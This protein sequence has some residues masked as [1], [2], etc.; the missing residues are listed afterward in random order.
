M[1]LI[2]WLIPNRKVVFHSPLRADELLSEINRITINS[3]PFYFGEFSKDKS[4]YYYGILSDNHFKL[5]RIQYGNSYFGGGGY[6][7][8][9]PV[10]SGTV[11]TAEAGSEIRV[12]LRLNGFV[13][14]LTLFWFLMF[15][16]ITYSAS[17]GNMRLWLLAVPLYFFFY[18]FFLW[19][20]VVTIEDLSKQFQAQPRE[21][22][23]P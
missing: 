18:L 5:R 4:K 7:M 21:K 1:G 11:E 8:F 20:A 6:N 15:G 9:R 14:I 13:M 17:D 19:E 3:W 10:I 2:K 23:W 22:D 16:L 12:T